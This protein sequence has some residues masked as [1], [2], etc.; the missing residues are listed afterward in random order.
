MN[1]PAVIQTILNVQ[2]GLFGIRY[3]KIVKSPTDPH[4][5]I[6]VMFKH[7]LRL[8][9]DVVPGQPVTSIGD[10][11]DTKLRVYRHTEYDKIKPAVDFVAECAGR[12]LADGFGKIAERKLHEDAIREAWEMSLFRGYIKTIDPRRLVEYDQVL[13]IVDQLYISGTCSSGTAI[14]QS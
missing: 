9:A 1:Q 5:V 4:F 11:L 13:E 10:E 2:D 3:L 12:V 6:D 14:Q 8:T 7:G